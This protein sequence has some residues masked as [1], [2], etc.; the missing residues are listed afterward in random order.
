MAFTSRR[1]IYI[2]RE[3]V[4]GESKQN[5]KKKEEKPLGFST[6]TKTDYEDVKKRYI[7]NQ[8]TSFCLR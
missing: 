2:R 7:V 1:R 3:G 5:K 4:N 8:Y 6:L